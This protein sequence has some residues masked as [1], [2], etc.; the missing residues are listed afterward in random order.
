MVDN[1]PNEQ[2]E[3]EV[4]SGFNNAL[5]GTNKHKMLEEA[6]E[7]GFDELLYYTWTCWYPI[8]DKPCNKCKMC[9]ERIIECRSLGDTT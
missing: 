9:K 8:G 3:R 5:R 2:S 4:F 1:L 7:L 6:K